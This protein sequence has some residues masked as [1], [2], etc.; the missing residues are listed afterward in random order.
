MWAQDE[1]M[2][3]HVV[4][5]NKPEGAGESDAAGDASATKAKTEISTNPRVF[6]EIEIN[7]AS[8]GRIEILVR[9]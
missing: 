3:E 7:G 4:K 9:S 5:T 6:M 8:A 2:Q 1:W